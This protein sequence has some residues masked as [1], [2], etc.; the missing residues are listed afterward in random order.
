MDHM[1]SNRLWFENQYGFRPNHST[2]HA[3]SKLITLIEAALSRKKYFLVIFLDVSKAFN[4]LPAE[5][6]AKKLDWYGLTGNIKNVIMSYLSG[7][8][9]ISEVGSIRSTEAAVGLGTPQGSAFSTTA[10]ILY[11]NDLPVAT[12]LDCILYADD[13]SLCA[14][15]DSLNELEVVANK[16]LEKISRW[17]ATNRLTLNAKKSQAIIFKPSGL[18]AYPVSLRLNGESLAQLGPGESTKFLGIRI[19]QKL[20]FKDHIKT[21]GGKVSSGLFALRQASGLLNRPNKLLL[22]NALIHSHL[23][24]GALI[25]GNLGTRTDLKRLEIIQKKAVRLVAGAHYNDHTGPLF[26][27]LNV[28][29][30]ADIPGYQAVS[31]YNHLGR[32][33][34]PYG[35]K[36]LLEPDL[37]NVRSSQRNNVRINSQPGSS[38]QNIILRSHQDPHVRPGVWKQR[39]ISAY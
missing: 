5:L 9:Q 10:Y 31:L 24:Y 16:E 19:D 22:Y 20:N 14:E 36:R 6:L 35:V 33:T 18:A 29:K 7:R 17:F 34:L 12:S 23:E 37:Q 25:W 11:N 4:C 15:F 39:K 13:T 38:L 21:I 32:G 1:N 2:T 26:K 27:S 3:V 28:L 8:K 30:F